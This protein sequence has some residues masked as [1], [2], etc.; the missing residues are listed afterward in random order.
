MARLGSKTFFGEIALLNDSSRSATAKAV[1]DTEIF[2]FSQVDFLWIVENTPV[3]ASKILFALG[4]LL[5]TRLNQA[6]INLEKLNQADNE[7]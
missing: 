3:I 7:E 6:N 4:S 1:Q 2:V 5:A